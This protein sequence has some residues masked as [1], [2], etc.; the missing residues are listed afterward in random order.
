MSA[1]VHPASDGD[2]PFGAIDARLTVFALANGMDL[3]KGEDYR[4]LEWFTEG[5]ERGILIEAVDSARFDVKVL[6]WRTGH[7][8]ELSVAAV[9]DA[10][11]ADDVTKLI[12][13][14]IETA[15]GLTT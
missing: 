8:E 11:E 10:V 7:A 9:D 2:G 15:N 14:A 13:E 6:C 12:L 5:L 1:A 3:S 4:R